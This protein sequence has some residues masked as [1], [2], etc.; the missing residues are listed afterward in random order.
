VHFAT[1][2]SSYRR[3]LSNRPLA[4]AA[5]LAAIFAIAGC[6]K[7]AAPPPPP[8]P[9]TNTAPAPTAE[10][11]ATPTAVSPGDSVV[12]TWHTT[13]ANEVSIEGIGQV[14]SSGTQVV[15]PADSTN[16]HLIARG[17]GG[18]ADATARVTVNAPAAPPASN[19]NESNV[20]DATFHQNV[21]DVFY[22]YDSYDIRP[23]EQAVISGDANFLNQ[24][25][26][27]KVVVGGYCDERGSVE[28]NLALGENRANAAKQALV[29]AGVSPERLRTVSYGKEKQFCTDHTESCWQQNRR[30]QFS[31]DQ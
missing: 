25:P 20:D 16:Y 1:R 27:L 10:I 29:T 13:N 31:I 26:E 2:K 19:L 5:S 12:L 30:A 18:T 8:P 9:L 22:D 23:D 3:V 4:L 28:Y 15:K 6:H 11:T 21:K 14:T 24:H 7:K 17:D